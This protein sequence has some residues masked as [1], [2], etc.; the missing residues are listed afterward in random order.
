VA[1]PLVRVELVF[2]AGGRLRPPSAAAEP[3]ALFQAQSETKV[4]PCCPHLNP[5]G[6]GGPESFAR[7]VLTRVPLVATLGLELSI[8]GDK[9]QALEGVGAMAVPPSF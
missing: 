9:P 1:L 8:L 4:R 3:A 6:R 2:C 5:L 7:L